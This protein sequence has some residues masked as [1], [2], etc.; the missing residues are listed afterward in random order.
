MADAQKIDYS[1]LTDDQLL[2]IA[3]GASIHAPDALDR[4]LMTPEVP[5]PAVRL[6]R[7]MMDFYQGVKQKALNSINPEEAKDYTAQVNEEIAK[8]EAGRKAGG[9][10]GMDLMRLGGNIATPLALLPGGGA[11]KLAR[12]GLGALAGGTMGYTNFNPENSETS[13]LINTAVGAFSG[14]TLNTVAPSLVRGAVQ[15]GQYLYNKGAEAVRGALARLSPTVQNEITN[16]LRITLQ[17]SGVDFDK[18]G[19]AIQ[20]AM[21]Q[22]AAQQMKLTGKLD[23]AQTLRKADIEAVAGPGSSTLG[24]VTQDPAQY[25]LERNLQKTEVNLPAVQRGE[26]GT[27]TQRFT[28]QDRAMKSYGQ[29]LADAVYGETPADA[30]AATPFQAAEN[31]ASTVNKEYS[32]LGDEVGNAY[33]IARK[34]LGAQTE[35][36]AAEFSKRATTALQDYSD[37]MP[38]PIAKRLQEFGFDLTGQAKPTKAFTVEEGDK[39]LKLVNKRYASADPAT[40]SALNEIRGALKD[41]LMEAG[42]AGNDS[43]QKFMDAISAASSR[44]RTFEPKPLASI[45]QDKANTSTF[46]QNQVLNGNP[47]DLK[48][49]A[50]VLEGAEG[51]TAALNDLKGQT[52]QYVMDKAT[53][54]GRAPFSGA[55][56]QDALRQIGEDRLR[57][58]FKP[59][60]LQGIKTLERGSLAMTY[61]PAFAAPNR[62][63]T[64]PSALGAILRYGN[65][66]PLLNMTTDPLSRE[67]DASATQKLLAQALSAE[68][69]NTSA[70]NAAQAATR[71]RIARLLLTNRAVN[72][73]VIPASG[74]EQQR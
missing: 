22:D 13:N 38:A 1:K 5:N 68:G 21:L 64:T 32:R 16:N 41:A 23:P 42:K 4:A 55:R 2:A 33:D 50:G 53:Q 69:A 30:R 31:V 51:G 67:I 26:S 47:N 27:L 74:L 37:V 48:A 70:R 20:D 11:T 19:P 36:P 73:G 56:Y 12:F 58:L 6:G 52:L 10:Q 66:V 14:G 71:D 60:E 25:T 8:Y 59:E 28:D 29:R 46:F 18:L 3:G 65:K 9:Q 62:S 15:G 39:L 44:F 43:A 61:E 54:G 72:L 35:L 17:R 57:V 45:V 34:T 40:Q 63:N 24:Q 7:G 49:L